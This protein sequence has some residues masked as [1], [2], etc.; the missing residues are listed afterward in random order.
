MSEPDLSDI[1]GDPFKDADITVQL[2][3]EEVLAI[4]TACAVARDFCQSEGTK[5]VFETV[6][7]KMLE[8]A[9]GIN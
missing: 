2:S 6:R 7:I 9:K 1:P 5:E 4:L 3:P 8:K